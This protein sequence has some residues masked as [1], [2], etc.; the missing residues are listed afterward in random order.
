MTSGFIRNQHVS[1]KKKER[2][3]ELRKHM[4]EAENVFWD[5]VR[6]RRLNH[7]K[8][9]R[10]Q[11][12]V[13]FIVDFFCC[14]LNLCVEIDGDVHNDDYQ[15]EYDK[16]KDDILSQNGLKVIRIKNE[17]LFTCPDNVR[18]MILKEIYSHDKP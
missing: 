12:I 15:R 13:G 1:D 3:R 7:L 16:E 17:D 18:D 9:R 8:F 2:S 11:V 4:T 10:Q 5:M 14:E 6:D